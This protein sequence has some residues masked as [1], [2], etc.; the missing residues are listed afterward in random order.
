MILSDIVWSHD[1][2]LHKIYTS[3]FF[4]VSEGMYHIRHLIY[5]FILLLLLIFFFFFFE[6]DVIKAKLAKNTT[7][8]CEGTSFIHK[9]KPMTCIAC[10]ARL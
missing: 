7:L 4:R 2:D 5:L 8:S 3:S 10:L 6:N 1:L 9:K